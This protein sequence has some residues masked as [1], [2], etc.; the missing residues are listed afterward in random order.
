MF[1]YVPTYKIFE[2]S[3]IDKVKNY[4]QENKN[5]FIKIQ[6]FLKKSILVKLFEENTINIKNG[7]DFSHIIFDVKDIFEDITEKSLYFEILK[8]IEKYNKRYNTVNFDYILN[9]IYYHGNKI[10]NKDI[11]Y[12]EITQFYHERF[13]IT[14]AIQVNFYKTRLN[15]NLS[16]KVSF[17]LKKEFKEEYENIMNTISLKRTYLNYKS[18]HC[19]IWAE[20]GEHKMINIKNEKDAVELLVNLSKLTLSLDEIKLK[21]QSFIIKEIKKNPSLFKEYF[22]LLTD[23]TKKL[24]PYLDNSNSLGMFDY[25]K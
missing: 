15:Y 20:L 13:G 23:E 18:F 3:E 10:L 1:K 4:I 11:F 2:N 5:H 25:I 8:N 17:I 7:F 9:R 14:Y 24:F 16:K 12:F 21:Y 6:K 22:F 19:S